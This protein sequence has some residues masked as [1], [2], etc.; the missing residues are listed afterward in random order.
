VLVTAD[1]CPRSYQVTVNG[2]AQPPLWDTGG[3]ET[4]ARDGMGLPL[5][6]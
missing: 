1:G 5:P 6:S 4:I 3:L 2:R